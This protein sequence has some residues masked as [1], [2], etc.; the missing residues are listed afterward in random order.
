MP[1]VTR[2]RSARPFA[3]DDAQRLDRRRPWLAHA[4]RRSSPGDSQT[5][6]QES[7]GT[8]VAPVQSGQMILTSNGKLVF[9]TAKSSS[10]NRAV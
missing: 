10:A 8:V 2:P 1:L 3:V 4:F 6:V 5:V 9:Q 7:L